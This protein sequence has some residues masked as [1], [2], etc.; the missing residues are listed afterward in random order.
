MT[1]THSPQLFIHDVSVQQ[2]GP[3]EELR[4]SLEASGIFFFFQRRFDSLI[5]VYAGEVVTPPAALGRH[6]LSKDATRTLDVPPYRVES[7][8]TV[9]ST[10]ATHVRLE[11]RMWGRI[12][13][14]HDGRRMLDIAGEKKNSSTDSTGMSYM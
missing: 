2:H 10:A 1:D 13:N 9:L 7:L 14:R 12:P 5:P 11:W 4:S 3:V 8:I 6:F